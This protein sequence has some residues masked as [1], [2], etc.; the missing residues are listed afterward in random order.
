[1]VRPPGA[2]C[3]GK[4]AGTAPQGA[5]LGFA[6]GKRG[7]GW[8]SHCVG[9]ACV[10]VLANVRRVLG[11]VCGLCGVG[12]AKCA[13]WLLEGLGCSHSDRARRGAGRPRAPAV[14]VGGGQ[15]LHFESR[16]GSNLSRPS[17]PRCPPGRAWG[18]AF[19]AAFMRF[20]ALRRVSAQKSGKTSVAKF[21]VPPHRPP[22]GRH[23]LGSARGRVLKIGQNLASSGA[24]NNS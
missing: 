17:A 6:T 7:A 1:M 11:C 14:G 21:K 23:A 22:S 5:R 8:A 18:R 10:G 13:D 15:S 20:G 9:A 3:A 19:P 12:V 2:F 4:C 24:H 16:F